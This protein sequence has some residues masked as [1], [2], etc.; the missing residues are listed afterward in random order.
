MR[1]KVQE[2]LDYWIHVL[3]LSSWELTIEYGEIDGAYAE[4][5]PHDQYD[6]AKLKF[7]L[8]KLKGETD[9]FIERTII[10]ELLHIL[11]RDRDELIGQIEHH[12]SPEVYKLYENVIEKSTENFIDKLATILYNQREGHDLRRDRKSGDST[13]SSRPD[14]SPGNSSNVP[15]L[16][17][18]KRGRTGSR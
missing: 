5:K 17:P 6:S 10:H 1:Q 2:Y 4:T 13:S 16:D 7:N 15:R 9:S 8:D 3:G 14:A 12:L 18:P 11:D